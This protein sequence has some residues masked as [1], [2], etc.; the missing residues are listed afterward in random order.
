MGMLLKQ[1]RRVKI[2]NIEWEDGR[3]SRPPTQLYEAQNV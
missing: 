3:S 1:Q 2:H